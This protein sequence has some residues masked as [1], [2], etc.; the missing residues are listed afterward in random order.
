MPAEGGRSLAEA[1]AGRVLLLDGAMSTM[2]DCRCGV[3]DMLCLTRPEAVAAVH[4]Q[5]VAAGADII[6]TNTFN[7]N[8]L[9]LRRFGA[10]HRVA[11]VCHAAACIA[12]READEADRPAWVAGCV[13]PG[14]VCGDFDRMRDAYA[15]AMTAL[16][17]GRVDALLVE[18]IYD[19]RS[20]R[21]AVAATRAAFGLAG[22]E[23][24]C[25]FSFSPSA[26][27]RLLSGE[28]LAEVVKELHAAEPLAV[29]VNCGS[30]AESLLPFVGLLAGEPWATMIYPSAGLP[31]AQGRYAATPAAMAEALRP[32]IE[33]ELVNIVGGCCGTTPEHIAAIGAVRS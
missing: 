15:E 25:M 2:V 32:A 31:D 33:S 9:S 27:G 1:M 21:A 5:Y 18:T 20:L 13:G 6:E 23:V 8:A 3:A 30:G 11:E 17:E 22:R 26:D 29:G 24:P 16:V 7:A 10:A 4:R 12:R 14:P 19:A 28:S